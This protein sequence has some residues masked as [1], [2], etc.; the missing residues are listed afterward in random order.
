M[1][2]AAIQQT[3]CRL[4]QKVEVLIPARTPSSTPNEFRLTYPEQGEPLSASVQPMS[5]EARLKAGLTGQKA[6]WTVYLQPCGL[7]LVAGETR[8]ALEGRVG[9]LKAQEPWKGL[10]LKLLVEE[11]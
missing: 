7:S 10:Y 9:L 11:I 8:L 1:R 4:G 6:A 2:P 5:H 3:L